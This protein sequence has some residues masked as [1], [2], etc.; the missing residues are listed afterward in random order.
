M[1]KLMCFN[2]PSLTIVHYWEM[3]HF[4]KEVMMQNIFHIRMSGGR[5]QL[6]LKASRAKESVLPHNAPL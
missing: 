6:R 3:L 5:G 4:D 2:I 1:A